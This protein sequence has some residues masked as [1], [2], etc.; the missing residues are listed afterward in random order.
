MNEILVEI[1]QQLAQ[2]EGEIRRL[3]HGR[4]QCWAGFEWLVVDLYPPVAVIRAFEAGHDEVIGFLAQWLYKQPQIQA[5]VAQSREGSD[6]QSVCLHGQVQEVMTAVEAGLK[7]EV[8]PLA[9]Q[10][11][12]LF[13][14]MRPGRQWVRDHAQGGKVLN[15]FAYTCAFSVAALAGEAAE[16][17]NLDMSSAALGWGRR[18]HQLNNHDSS[19]VRYFALNL[20]KSWSRVRKFGPYDLIII[21]PPSFQKGS[22]DARKDYAKIVRRLDELTA[23]KA[24]VLACHNDPRSDSTFLRELFAT[25]APDFALVERLPTAEDFP[26]INPEAGLKLLAYQKR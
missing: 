22:F 15:L 9:A 10:N 14:D 24:R 20:M 17:V 16:V 1:E 13:N 26:D 11:N 18:N 4:G 8:H 12:G 7:Y 5:V 6:S 2:S 21:D 25:E 19:R 23:P 3:F